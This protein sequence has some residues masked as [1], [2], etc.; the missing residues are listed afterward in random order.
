MNLTSAQIAQA[1]QCSLPRAENWREA[2]SD[3]M[4]VFAIDTPARAARFLAQIAH[5]SGRLAYT[6]E[7][8]GPT[9]AQLRYEGR[10]DLGNVKPGDGY[11]FR[12]HGLIQITGRANHAAA[13]DGLRKFMP[14]VPDFELEPEALEVP[15]WAAASAAW[16]WHSHGCNE[17]ADADQF[18]VIT[19]RINGGINGYDDRLALLADAQRALA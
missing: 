8:W 3:S 1:C 15:R 14:G 2:L 4:A 10:E 18:L 11:R 17:L 5:E 19:R 9:P 6:H 12:G 13:R 16:Y 7:I